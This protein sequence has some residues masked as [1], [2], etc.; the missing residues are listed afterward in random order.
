MNLIIKY[1]EICEKLTI[2]KNI[3]INKDNK[4]LLIYDKKYYEI[5]I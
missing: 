1:I 4:N 5:N 2:L 3:E